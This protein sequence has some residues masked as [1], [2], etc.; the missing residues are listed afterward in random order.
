MTKS[1]IMA[2]SA[3]SKSLIKDLAPL[4]KVINSRSSMPV[5]LDFL[6]RAGKESV[7]AIAANEE[8][9]VAVRLSDAVADTPGD[10]CTDSKFLMNML[11]KLGGSDVNMSVDDN[12]LEITHARGRHSVPVH[13]TDDFPETPQ[14]G[15]VL[16]EFSI[17]AFRFARGIELTLGSAAEDTTCPVIC[18]VNVDIFEDHIVFVATNKFILSKYTD[19]KVKTGIRASF[20]ISSKTCGILLALLRDGDTLRISFSD[21]R[22][23]ITTDRYSVVSA[24][25]NGNYPNYERVIPSNNTIS[26]TID[27]QQLIEAVERVGLVADQGESGLVFRLT[28][29]LINLSM[30]NVAINRC[31]EESIPCNAD[32]DSFEVKATA[33]YFKAILDG[34][35]SDSV[36]IQGR[37]HYN[38]ITLTPAAMPEGE[39]F[40]SLCMP[41]LR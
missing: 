26:A 2:F 20:T 39:E 14:M 11:R 19:W 18:G 36:V 30:S 9:A 5:M 33:F 31:A 35:E 13:K 1:K 7:F 6:F 22:I 21:K 25:I 41:V 28:K 40:I 27:R 34:M 12:T 38:P 10:F 29:D 24:L 16:G 8:C 4:A 23:R 37:A 17:D 32:V 3:N 15:T